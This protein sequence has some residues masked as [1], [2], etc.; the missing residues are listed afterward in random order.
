MAQFPTEPL[1][2][3]NEE[4]YLM[5]AG[6]SQ[7]AGPYL[8]IAILANRQYKLKQKNNGQEHSQP[9]KEDDLVLPV[10]EVP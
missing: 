1:Y 5:V 9:V 2:G 8:I 4:V 7:P 3:V 10:P 6:Q